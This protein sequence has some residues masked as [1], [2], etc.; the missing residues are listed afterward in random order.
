MLVPV[1]GSPGMYALVAL[2]GA[3]AGSSGGAGAALSPS[4]VEL[5]EAAVVD[6]ASMLLER[7]RAIKAKNKIEEESKEGQNMITS[8][9]GSKE[10][11]PRNKD[12][13]LQGR[14]ERVKPDGQIEYGIFAN[15]AISNG[16]IVWPNEIIDHGDFENNTLTGKGERTFPNGA[17]LIGEFKQ[18]GTCE[19]GKKKWG[20]WVE[21]GRFNREG[22][23]HS[24]IGY[25][26]R[27]T[28][29]SDSIGIDAMG[30]QLGRFKECEEL[31]PYENG[32]LEGIVEHYTHRIY[33]HNTGEE[34]MN[35]SG[36]FKQ[37]NLI[38]G[39]RATYDMFKKT[40]YLFVGT[41]NE[42]GSPN[43]GRQYFPLDGKNFKNGIPES[44]CCV[45]Q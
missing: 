29:F 8:T 12:N 34:S 45:I 7:S 4:Q 14:G 10:I 28:K 24:F 35:F 11:G 3:G 37:G 21:E 41:F 23:L 18:D 20:N 2:P 39:R 30:N 31:G 13:Q 1:Q 15:G 36:K 43:T 38:E 9:D 25:T 19:Y 17:T 32:K 40:I 16:W 22:Q 33:Y 5:K 42:D 6:I 44:T 26:G 27:R